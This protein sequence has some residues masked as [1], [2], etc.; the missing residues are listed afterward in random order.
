MYGVQ[1]AL[2]L[3]QLWLYNYWKALLDADL[4]KYRLC[5]VKD[6]M[7]EDAL[8]MLGR[9]GLL[10]FNVVDVERAAIVADFSLEGFVGKAAMVHFSMHPDNPPQYSM[11]LAREVTDD[12]LNIWCES[13]SDSPF[14][15]TLY[16]LTPVT[17][18]AACAFVRRVGFRKIG[19]LPH[20]Q[21]VDGRE[22]VDAQITIKERRDGR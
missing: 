9:I 1:P 15:Y 7:V 18:R 12:I 5:D 2:D 13:G 20:G 10:S 14:L 4:L 6:P 8:A 17:N 16:G 11:K 19:T 21:M 22:Y 3:P